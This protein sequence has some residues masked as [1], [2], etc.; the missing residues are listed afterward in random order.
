MWYK[1]EVLTDYQLQ[2]KEKYLG[3]RFLL[4]EWS[5][6]AHAARAYWSW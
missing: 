4:S 6:G 2:L 1:H 5:V 3:V